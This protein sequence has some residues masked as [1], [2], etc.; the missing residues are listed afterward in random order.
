MAINMHLSEY[1]S[2]HCINIAKF[3]VSSNQIQYRYITYHY[4]YT[5]SDIQEE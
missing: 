2:Y 1:V 5:D 3:M 4:V